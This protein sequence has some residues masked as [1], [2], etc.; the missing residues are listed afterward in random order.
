MRE[1]VGRLE[2]AIAEAVKVASPALQEVINDLQ[3]QR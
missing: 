1:R 2:E 3:A